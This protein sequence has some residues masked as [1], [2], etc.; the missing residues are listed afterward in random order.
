MTETTEVCPQCDGEATVVRERRSVP[1]GQRRVEIDDE[2][3]KCE[4]C[5]ETFYTV[6]QADQRHDRAV[7]KARQDDNLLTPRQ[8]KNVRDDLG[9]TQKQ[10]EEVLGVGEKTCVRWEAGRVCQNAA[11]DRL[12]RL[13]VANRSNLRVLAA[14]NGVALPDAAAPPKTSRATHPVEWDVDLLPNEV[15][16]KKVLQ[17][18]GSLESEEIMDSQYTA[19]IDVSSR[20]IATQKV[21]NSN[22]QV[23]A[24][25]FGAKPLAGR[26]RE[27]S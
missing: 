12:I 10:F 16:F 18:G 24:A 1:L 19:L 14:I 5:A 22:A 17:L 13:L 23:F 25:M 8:I 15:H 6:A 20:R 4:T 26:N 21:T 2:Y 27:R 9:L 11:T 7:E 3:T